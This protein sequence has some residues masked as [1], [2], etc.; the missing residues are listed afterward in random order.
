VKIKTGSRTKKKDI[1]GV[2]RGEVVNARCCG[3]G[4]GGGGV[5]KEWVSATS[6]GRPTILYSLARKER[7]FLRGTM[8]GE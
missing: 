4:G 1:E 7:G 8:G 5:K 2:S 3:G 6:G